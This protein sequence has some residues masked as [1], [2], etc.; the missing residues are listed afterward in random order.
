MN[1]LDV[2][3]DI[4]RPFFCQ[5]NWFEEKTSNKFSFCNNNDPYAEFVVALPNAIDTNAIDTNAIDT[6]AIDVSIPVKDVSYK[7]TFFNINEAT[8]YM[9][10]HVKNYEEGYIDYL[11]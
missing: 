7:K 1:K 9:K 4:I 8:S 3:L 5:K 2:I 11:G 10:M 6:N